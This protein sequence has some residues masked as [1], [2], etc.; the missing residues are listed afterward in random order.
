M[1]YEE[2]REAPI[3]PFE[4]EMEEEEQEAVEEKEIA[5][6]VPETVEPPPFVQ[7]PIVFSQV[8]QPE[9]KQEEE[10]DLDYLFEVPEPGDNDMKVD[11]LVDAPEKE[12]LS[13]MFNVSDED[14]MGEGGS[15]MSDLVDVSEEDVMGGDSD[16]SDLVEVSG[17]PAIKET[18]IK[19]YKIRPRGRRYLRDI[20]PTSVRGVRY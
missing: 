16:L 2:D 4:E 14:I 6:K 19:R 9:I 5:T 1:A 20:P 10:D 7:K 12:D 15:D 8:V 17:E 11:H 3:T 13:D 18:E